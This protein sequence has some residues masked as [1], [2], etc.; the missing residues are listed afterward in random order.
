M[1]GV[2][3]CCLAVGHGA[4]LWCWRDLEAASVSA[5]A[6]ERNPKHRGGP[7]LSSLAVCSLVW[8]G[9]P[10][11]HLTSTELDVTSHTENTLSLCVVSC[12]GLWASPC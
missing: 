1:H 3:W 7:G 2:V 10:I 8:P 11:T 9:H 12:A 5:A 4:G 6:C